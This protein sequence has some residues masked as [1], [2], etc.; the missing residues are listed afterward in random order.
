MTHDHEA[1]NWASWALA[2]RLAHGRY[3]GPSEMYLLEGM[4]D[5]P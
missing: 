3:W 1:D 5:I 2:L 4:G